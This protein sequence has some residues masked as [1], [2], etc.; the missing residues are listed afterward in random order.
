MPGRQSTGGWEV[1]DRLWVVGLIAVT[2]AEMP[3]SLSY[4]YELIGW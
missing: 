4:C 2:K 1:Q 3:M